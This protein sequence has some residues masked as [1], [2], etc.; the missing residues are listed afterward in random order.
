MVSRAGQAGPSGMCG[1]GPLLQVQG[2][3]LKGFQ[4]ESDLIRLAFNHSEYGRWS[5]WGTEWACDLLGGP[6]G[7]RLV[8][9]LYRI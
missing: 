8:K 4:H 1:L 7:I 9:L 3:V 2:A 6:C 5:E